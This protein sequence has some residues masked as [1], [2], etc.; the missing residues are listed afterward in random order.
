MTGRTGSDEIYHEQLS[1]W[2]QALA[3]G[4]ADDLAT[5][6]AEGSTPAHVRL[7]SDGHHKKRH[8][9]LRTQLEFVAGAFADFEDLLAVYLQEGPPVAYDS[10]V[11][12]A[13]RFL[14][15][16]ERAGDLTPEQRDHVA[17][18]QARHAVEAAA[19]E[20]RAGHLRFQQLW[21]ATDR[22]ANILA[23]DAGLRIYLNPI[24]A[25][26]RFA[27]AALLDTE[28]SLPADVLFFAVG[29]GISTAVLEPVGREL[30]GELACWETCTLKHWTGLSQHAGR[31][32]IA[33]ICDDL[34]QMGLVVFG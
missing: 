26:S 22:V 2:T 33:E 18:Q 25:W 20:N 30:V 11:V 19:R 28:A 8:E 27:T 6:L 21:H 9:A 1:R 31:E 15:W 29:T 16:V 5:A 34:A 3:N 12:D 7:F 23:G 24:R 17:C 14:V 32:E 13:E 10:T 4:C